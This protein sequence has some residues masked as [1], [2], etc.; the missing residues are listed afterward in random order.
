VP[1]QFNT[2]S[3]SG[4]LKFRLGEGYISDVSDGGARV[5]SLLSL[6]SLVRKLKLDFR[7]VFSKG[8]FYN[9]MQGSIQVDNGVA[10]T[11]DA[12]LNGV[13]AD[14][15]MMGYTDLNTQKIDYTMLVA[16]QITSSI[17][18]I[19]AWLVNPATGLAV[20]AID[21]VLHSARVISEIEYTITGTLDEPVVTLKG[22][23]SR[24]IELPEA[25]FDTPQGTQPDSK[26][27][28]DTQSTE[29]TA[30]NVTTDLTPKDNP[31]LESV[32]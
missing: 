30:A 9:S 27:T 21:Q 24:E 28:S 3:L 22:K 1:Y 5:F 20:L 4:E 10:H 26:E 12:Q 7:D 23:K 19:V 16:P 29:P 13:P 11:Q 32:Q 8:F 15:T 14:L 2:E 6:D 17:P 31:P 18:V 25:E